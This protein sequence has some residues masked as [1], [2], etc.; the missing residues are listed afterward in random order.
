KNHYTVNGEVYDKVGTDVPT[1]VSDMGFKDIELTR[2]KIRP[3]MGTDQFDILFLIREQGSLISEVF[4]VLGRLDVITK[5]GKECNS[6]LKSKKSLLKTRYEDLSS[7]D[8]KLVNYTGFEKVSLATDSLDQ[9]NKLILELKSTLAYLKE[10]DEK[11]EKYS[12]D[13]KI[14]EPSSDVKI[15]EEVNTSEVNKLNA[16]KSANDKI[17][18]LSDQISKLEEVDQVSVE[19]FK[20]DK[21]LVLVSRLSSIYNLYEEKSKEI[22]SLSDVNSIETPIDIN[23]SEINVIENLKSARDQI[24][25]LDLIIEEIQSFIESSNSRSLEIESELHDLL[26]GLEEC[27]LCEQTMKGKAFV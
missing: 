4:S 22:I 16:L 15:P 5:A 17:V 8:R 23:D 11:L 6:D 21:I 2:S 7:V 19:D 3:Q 18:S 27:P 13:I 12:K 14:L 9:D 24:V 26:G 1:V 25:K 10:S 20:G